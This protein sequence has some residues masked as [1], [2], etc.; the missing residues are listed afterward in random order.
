MSPALLEARALVC[1]LLCET[2]TA[3]PLGLV[4]REPRLKSPPPPLT[5]ST[6]PTLASPPSATS[7]T[8]ERRG[9]E[10]S[11]GGGPIVIDAAAWAKEGG[12]GLEEALVSSEP[13]LEAHAEGTAVEEEREEGKG[14]GEGKGEVDMEALKDRCDLRLPHEW[15]PYAR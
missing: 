14:E 15:Y 2:I 9:E 10:R 8:S 7:A 3:Q 13:E 6:T 4:S 12:Y 5:P 11:S 1:E